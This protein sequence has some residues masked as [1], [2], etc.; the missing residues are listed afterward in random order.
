LYQD[1]KTVN[2]QRE[3]EFARDL[4]LRAGELVRKGFTEGFT[5]SY[6]GRVDLV[7]EVD[8]RSEDFIR[9]EIKKEFPEDSFFGEERGGNDFRRGRVWLVD[10]LDGTTNFAH[11]LKI[12]SVSIAF[13]EN[14]EIRAGAVCQPMTDEVFHA[15]SGGGAFRNGQAISV[16]GR[17]QL[18]ESFGVTGFPYEIGNYLE[19]ILNELR[20]ILPLAHGVRRLGS[21]SMDLCYVACG[22]FDFFWEWNLKPWDVA[23]GGLI[24]RESGGTVTDF[25]NGSD[26]IGSGQLL[27]SNGFIHSELV[28]L[29]NGKNFSQITSKGASESH[30]GKKR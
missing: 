9:Q 26:F 11:G 4:S 2:F 14:G 24:V 6:K 5:V 29:F 23:A 10:P 22:I 13:L 18:A 16:S 20:V 28:R 30:D 7:T 17:K 27:A 3:A 19:R 1:E 15:W 8:L 25:A 21:A 12:F